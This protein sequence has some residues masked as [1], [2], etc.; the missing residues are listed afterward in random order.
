VP[1]LDVVRELTSETGRIY[2]EDV[3]ALGC[4]PPTRAPRA[5]EHIRQMIAMIAKLVATGHAYVAEGHVLFDVSSKAD[6][7]KLSRR[8]LDEMMAGARVEVA[9]YKRSPMDFVLWKPS[10]AHAGLG[11]PV[12]PRPSRLAHRMLGDERVLSRRDFRHSRR[13]H[14]SRVSASRERNRA[15]RR[16]ASRPSA[17]QLL[18]AQRLPECRRR[19]NVQEPRQFRDDSR[20]AGGLA[21]RGAALNMLRSHYRQPMD[22]TVHGMKESWGMLERWYDAAEPDRV[23]PHRRRIS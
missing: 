3:A 7:G 12:G 21:G 4:L 23:A 8:S 15:K 13:R 22:W 1:I 5:T 9:P 17:R 16:R 6:Y 20:I 2:D 19:E 11:Q 18:D 14:R 10:D